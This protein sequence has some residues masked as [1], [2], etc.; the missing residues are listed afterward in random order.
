MLRHAFWMMARVNKERLQ[1][2]IPHG[3]PN[4]TCSCWMTCKAL[5]PFS[6]NA[7]GIRLYFCV[8]IRQYIIGHFKHY[9]TFLTVNVVR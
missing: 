2:K 3:L 9:P 5:D 8:E 1:F 6:K 7:R 4:T